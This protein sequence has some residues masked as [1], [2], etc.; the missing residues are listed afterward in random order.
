L[1][2]RGTPIGRFFFPRRDAK[3]AVEPLK[4]GKIGATDLTFNLAPF[5]KIR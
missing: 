2:L 5:G 1:S 4:T 3:F